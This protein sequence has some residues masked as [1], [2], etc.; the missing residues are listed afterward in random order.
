MEAHPPADGADE[1]AAQVEAA[2]ASG[3]AL[4]IRGGGTKSFYGCP[5]VGN[6]LS[7]AAH[8]GIVH[9]EPSELV[10]T[11]RA[12]TP[13]RDIE[14]TLRRNGQML[15]FE[16]PYFGGDATWGG[17][18]ACGFSGPRRPF[19]GSARDFV[20]GCRIVN[21]RGEILSFGGE[22]M[23]NVAGFDVSRLMVGALGTL[24][25]L[26]EVSVKVLPQPECEITLSFDL[27]WEQARQKMVEYSRGVWPI[28]A[29]AYDGRL[30]LRLSGAEIAAAAA[31]R[32]LG[33]D[34]VAGGDSY[35]RS[36]RE[37]THPFFRSAGDL[38]RLSLPPAADV[39]PLP[40]EWLWDW[41]GAQRWLWT[42]AAGEEIRTAARAVGGHALLFRAAHPPA[43]F[44]QDLDPSLIALHRRLKSAFDPKH[45]LNPGRFGEGF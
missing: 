29:L 31:A 27:A 19:T 12:G 45:I 22:V 4:E 13:L 5:V 11:A 15:G 44:F 17:T 41:G 33:G 21:G 28:S 3:L 37:Q 18:F 2:M 30:W 35:W 20:L 25:V 26:L 39:P 34:P 23:K 7:V 43:R 1:I 10:L 16:P 8:T 24:G 40:G 32:R 42:W 36:L 38:W 14:E 6:T 9:Y